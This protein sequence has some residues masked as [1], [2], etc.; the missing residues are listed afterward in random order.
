MIRRVIP[1]PTE[2]QLIGNQINAAMIFAWTDL[3][4]V[5]WRFLLSLSRCRVKSKRGRIRRV[6]HW[7]A[8][9]SILATLFASL[10]VSAPIMYA[11][12]LRGGV[13]GHSG[14]LV[15]VGV[16]LFEVKPNKTLHLVIG[17]RPCTRLELP[18]ARRRCYG[19][20]LLRHHTR[21]SRRSGGA[22][23]QQQPERGKHTGNGDDPGRLC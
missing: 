23:E 22:L 3:I 1:Q 2:R 8:T 12:D 13:V 20:S 5:H 15:G 11:T 21:A 16:A 19:Q 4:N 6:K 9:L 10:V 18:A 17:L 14:P 7:I